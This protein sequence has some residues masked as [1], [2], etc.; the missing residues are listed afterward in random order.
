MELYDHNKETYDKAMEVL[1]ESNMCA[2][3]QAPGLGKTFVTMQLLNTVFAGMKVLYVVP[4][5]SIEHAIKMYDDWNYPNVEFTTY[6]GLKNYEP[7]HD[8]IVL[9]EVHKAGAEKYFTYVQRILP[10]FKYVLGLSATPFRY[11]DGMRDMAT[12]IF[13]NNV[14]YGPDIKQAVERNLVPKFAYVYI[15]T[16]MVQV[17]EEL[18]KKT[19]DNHV[20]NLIAKL[21]SDYSLV[22]QVRAQIEPEHKKIIVFYPNIET[23][24]SGD[25]DLKQ[26]FDNDLHIYEMHSRLSVKQRRENL[27]LFSDDSERSVLKVVD[28]INEGVHVKGVTM[29]IFIRRTTSGNVFIQQIGRVMSA[30]SVA[31]PKV[32]DLCGNYANLKVLNQN[33]EEVGVEINFVDENST[34]AQIAKH[35]LITALLFATKATRVSWEKIFDRV[36]CTWSDQDDLILT[37]YYALEGGDVCMRIPGKTRGDCLKRASELKLSRVQKWTPEEDDI[38]RRFYVDERQDVAK[39]L[40]GRTESA[41]QSRVA[42]LEILP[43]WYPEEEMKLMRYWDSDGLAICSKLPRHSIRD[44]SDKAKKLGLDMSKS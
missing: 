19:N 41:I 2:I 31:K 30:K 5:R 26:W 24:I 36:Y 22:E 20:L 34:E 44:I 32:I 14:V 4:Y 3:I 37:K 13:G 16:D 6:T 27:R 38:L 11:L 10:S 9:D 28:M 21:V 18:E 1:S 29:L 8:V 12:E 33:G 42:K 39:R 35:N 15:P 43:R 40:P 17:A 25:E 23:L 7:R